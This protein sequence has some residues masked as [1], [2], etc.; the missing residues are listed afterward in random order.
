ME[1]AHRLCSVVTMLSPLCVTD[2]T[3][4]LL[5][6]LWRR[7]LLRA[8]VVRLPGTKLVQSLSFSTLHH[9]HR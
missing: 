4:A 9:K 3:H 5:A 7:C 1:W 2:A 6:G 8:G